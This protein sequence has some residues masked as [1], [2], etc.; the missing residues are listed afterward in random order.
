MGAVGRDAAREWILGRF[1]FSW[2]AVDPSAQGAGVGGAL[3]DA[4][5]ARARPARAWLVTH[6]DG[7]RARE[8]YDRRGWHELGRAELGWVPGERAIMGLAPR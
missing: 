6:G 2:F 3:Y 7:S 8:M 1:A 5:L 4:I